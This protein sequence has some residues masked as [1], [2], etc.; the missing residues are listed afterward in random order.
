V[1]PGG[2]VAGA[3]GGGASESA[4]TSIPITAPPYHGLEPQLALTYNSTIGNDWLGVGWSLT[5]IGAIGRISATRGIPRFSDDDIF[6]LNGRDLIPCST[7][8]IDD[9]ACR[10]KIA[11]AKSPGCQGSD[12]QGKFS[13][14]TTND[15]SGQLICR[16]WSQTDSNSQRW[17][18]TGTDGTV[19]RYDPLYMTPRGPELFRT[20]VVRDLR[21]NE[22]VYQ[23]DR[24]PPGELPELRAVDYRDVQLHFYT[25]PRLDT[26]PSPSSATQITLTNRLKTLAVTVGAKVS[27]AYALNFTQSPNNGRST[28]HGVQEYGNDVKVSDSGD[29]TGA[30]SSDL[31]PVQTF[32][33]DTG[34][35]AKPLSVGTEKVVGLENG[36]QDSS[37]AVP[38]PPPVPGSKPPTGSTQSTD[39]RNYNGHYRAGDV[40]GTGRT[41]VVLLE[42]PGGVACPSVD[43]IT[44][45]GAKSVSTSLDRANIDQHLVCPGT[46]QW[47]LTDMN[48]DGTADL[49]FL[50]Q[51]PTGINGKAYQGIVVYLSHGDGTFSV[52]PVVTPLIQVTP[53][54][55]APSC[56]TGD[57]EGNH[58]AAVVCAIPIPDSPIS[59]PRNCHE[60]LATYRLDNPS[61]ALGVEFDVPYDDDYDG[62]T[63]GTADLF[64]GQADLVLGDVD[65]DGRSDVIIVIQA[66]SYLGLLARTLL[67]MTSLGG[68][69]FNSRPAVS[70]T[71]ATHIGWIDPELIVTDLNGDGRADIVALDR[72]DN[73]AG[74]ARVET[75]ISS[76]DTWTLH[77]DPVPQ[78]WQGRVG[79]A[80]V[81]ASFDGTPA[82]GLTFIVDH[83]QQTT[84]S[85]CAAPGAPLI[86]YDHPEEVRVA[87][88]GDGTFTWPSSADDC[89]STQEI[90]TD[91]S[92]NFFADL[93]GFF[94]GIADSFLS[95]FTRGPIRY[96]GIG[97]AGM[98]A[99]GD[100]QSD[101]IFVNR[102]PN[103]DTPDL[104]V[105]YTSPARSPSVGWQAVALPDDGRT[106]Y[107]RV[108]TSLTPRATI[109]QPRQGPVVAGCLHHPTSDGCAPY[110]ITH[111]DLQVPEPA[112]LAANWRTIDLD[113][114]GRPDLVYVDNSVTHFFA[115]DPSPV[116][117]TM[118]LAYEPRA[119]GIGWS[120]T[121]IVGWFKR[122]GPAAMGPWQVADLA[123]DGRLGLLAVELGQSS[124]VVRA[125]SLDL[126]PP[127][128]PPGA[129]CF[130]HP[131]APGCQPTLAWTDR[132][133]APM[134]RPADADSAWRVVDIDGDHR[135]DLVEVTSSGN[136]FVPVTLH[137]DGP[138]QNATLANRWTLAP[139]QTLNGLALDAN[140]SSWLVGNFTGHG[141]TDLAH[142]QQSTSSVHLDLW[143]PASDG[144]G[145]WIRQIVNDTNLP[146]NTPTGRWTD[147]DTNGDDR[148]DLVM[149]TAG[150]AQ[151]GHK[152]TVTV[153]RSTTNTTFA[154]DDTVT[155]N[156]A[157]TAVADT[158]TTADADGGGG[159]TFTTVRATPAGYRIDFAETP[160]Q[161]DRV[162]RIDNG[163][164]GSATFTYRPLRDMK[165]SAPYASDCGVPAYIGFMSAASLQISDGIGDSH[166]QTF[167]YTCPQWS[168][169]SHRILGW[170]VTATTQ[171]ATA[172]TPDSTVTITH[173]LSPLC[174]DQPTNFTVLSDGRT[175]ESAERSYPPASSTSSRSC[176]PTSI[177]TRACDPRDGCAAHVENDV[178]DGFGNPVQRTDLGIS[179]SGGT[180]L[181]RSMII[182]YKAPGETNLVNLPVSVAVATP[183]GSQT[184]PVSQ[185]TFCYD[186]KCSGLSDTS[187]GLLTDVT[188]VDIGQPTANRHTHYEYDPFGN[189]TAII[190]A[191]GARTATDYDPTEHI[192]PT[193]VTD[194]LGHRTSEVWD[195]ILSLPTAQTDQNGLT[196]AYTYDPLGRL[197]DTTTP[198]G[199]AFHVRYLD[200][201][202]SATQRI[203]ASVDDGSAD[204]I[205][206]ET[207]FDGLGRITLVT[208]KGDDPTRTEA[209]RTTYADASDHVASQTHW[210]T[211][212]ALRSAPGETYHYDGLGRVRSQ[213]HPDGTTLTQS[214][215]GTATGSAV[216]RINEVGNRQT[217]D[218]DSW[219]RQTDVSQPTTSG[220]SATLAYEYDA[221]DR[222]TGIRDA[223]DQTTR[224]WDS[225]GQLLTEQ[226][227][228]RG[229]TNYT[230]DRVGNVTTVTDARDKTTTFTDDPLHRPLSRRSYGDAGPTLWHY[231][232]AGHG[233]SIGKLTSVQTPSAVGCPSSVGE[234]YA[235][236]NQ[237][238]QATATQCVASRSA[239]ET[240]T[241]DPY[242]RPNATIYPDGQLVPMSYA[243]SGRLQSEGRYAT[244]AT[245]TPS[246]QLSGL[247]LG[248]GIQQ[249][250]TYNTD[251][252]WLT[253]IVD[254]APAGADVFNSTINRRADGNIDVLG[255]TTI[256]SDNRTLGYNSFDQL[257]FTSGDVT[258]TNQFDPAGNI[259]KRSD[260]GS[261]SYSSCPSADQKA[262]PHG[263]SEIDSFGAQTMIC[264]DATG[265]RTKIDAGAEHQ[266]LTWTGSGLPSRITTTWPRASTAA[267]RGAIN[268]VHLT[269]G[270]EGQLVRQQLADPYDIEYFGPLAQWQSDR[271]LVDNLYFGSTLIARTNATGVSYFQDDHLG[272]PRVVTDAAGGVRARISVDPWGATRTES[273]NTPP[274]IPGYAGATPIL[275]SQYD[276]MGARLYDPHL[277]TFASADALSPSSSD[278]QGANRYAYA[279]NNPENAVDPTG[280]Q[281]VDP[282][283]Q[284][285]DPGLGEFSAGVEPD[286][287]DW[288]DPYYLDYQGALADW[289]SPGGAPGEPAVTETAQ[290]GMGVSPV[291]GATA[292][293]GQNSFSVWL[294]TYY[295]TDCGGRCGLI[296]YALDKGWMTNSD[297]EFLQ[298][299]P[300]LMGVMEPSAG[301]VDVS[302]PLKDAADL[303][304]LANAQHGYSKGGDLAERWRV[305]GT[306]LSQTPEGEWVTSISSTGA[307]LTGEQKA[308][309][310][311]FNPDVNFVSNP[312]N[313]HA[314]GVLLDNAY[315]NG[316]MPFYL[317][318]TKP[319]CLDC[320]SNGSS[321]EYGGQL[322]PSGNEWLFTPPNR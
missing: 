321:P 176:K 148:P 34:S 258:T 196:T 84:A 291:Q 219:G 267:G 178:H 209:T 83:P 14:Y 318:T 210:A 85:P 211:T 276:Q 248:N 223:A 170:H 65:G 82:L 286:Y 295:G 127:V 144:T 150:P 40:T 17:W 48:G 135:S 145:R 241:Y 102:R 70:L 1:G 124:L 32:T 118:V 69:Q 91:I 172:A 177:T 197:T 280:H 105:D 277:G 13:Y 205:F 283:S 220:S 95:G 28:L 51:G 92:D 42:E 222:I 143:T 191:A 55:I 43:V 309:V 139:G 198:T 179:S 120:E 71:T 251:R 255:S 254:S 317:Y 195:P 212:A 190:D 131:A 45:F 186:D 246:G 187:R 313:I 173:A 12:P 226:D 87:S 138:D 35:L 238:R 273:G 263:V 79:S 162:T 282:G 239:T 80:A 319:A 294:Q 11:S 275:G 63:C 37:T 53:T 228:D 125:M 156:A 60:R 30:S 200:I 24:S 59:T 164:G 284:W 194:A 279:R 123:G 181:S 142:L 243:P 201:G 193:A 217:D 185:E 41:G 163:I 269:Y 266:D 90:T 278:T 253:G 112:P 21:K 235:Y 231:D 2:A 132:S 188:N 199:Q 281:D 27:R 232:E 249:R 322:L 33:T 68:G 308:L 31:L 15:R 262:H 301:S 218:Y 67:T 146:P 122:T 23:W 75:A 116:P 54:P 110:T 306:L 203:Q 5:G 29:V 183:V 141:R 242:G 271:G 175:L 77:D 64:T 128:I 78:Y 153:L 133:S 208:R 270:A 298:I 8:G 184:V 88:N 304:E 252:G 259:T 292:S 315:A 303:A 225:L 290:V 9:P 158:W 268:D 320:R 296:G 61:V 152:D 26:V 113:G 221:A 39:A 72:I 129:Y 25:E 230:Y 288:L 265:N 316:N 114:H 109:L 117:A 165:D 38:P 100:G 216:T 160:N 19:S 4:T 300:A 115:G 272:T 56:A 81:S 98:D 151:P 50:T 236:D 167:S 257:T 247:T 234:S 94:Q 174:G 289:E 154:A 260:R 245:Y 58:H 149:L 103:Q 192:Y 206:T 6:T 99:D 36:S 101:V 22:V 214:Y 157:P 20:T 134:T 86:T 159:T 16:A 49:A 10:F 189:Q 155:L 107:V 274:G 111:E 250:W 307:P 171:P 66:Y 213:T 285:D 104:V 62:A 57:T 126:Y 297:M 89:A 302:T 97:G 7:I 180:T 161:A 121:P 287:T 207:H 312:G 314:E 224:T 264:S 93:A 204:G 96:S 233:P 46:T 310:A 215:D 293:G 140:Q 202:Q 182:S 106:G 168:F 227:P 136:G 108:D 244:A 76:G 237:G 166:T 137:N 47:W 256:G 169:D 74:E 73:S 130:K 305:V 18:V 44:V 261:Y 119:D 229:T 299:L 311:L 147:F 240:T 52:D 3:S